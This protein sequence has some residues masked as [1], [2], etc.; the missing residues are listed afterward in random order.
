[1][2]R[3]AVAALILALPAAAISQDTKKTDQK[4]AHPSIYDEKVDAKEQIKTA[5]ALARRDARRVL[6]MF[7]FN[8]C[9]WC[10]KLHGLFASDEAIRTLLADEYVLAMVDVQAQNA[11]DILRDCKT[12]LSR[13][14]LQKGVGYPFLAVLDG[15]G[16]V[17]TAQRTDPLEVGDHHDPGKV[18]AFLEKWVA[19]KVAASKVFEDG[20]AK[21]SRDDKLVFLHFGAPWCGWCH[22]LE[23]FLARD[24][25]APIFGREFVDVK[26]DLDRMA[27][28]R[29]IL[30]RYNADASGGIPWFVFLDARGTAIVTSDGPKGNIG[31]PGTP[32]GIEH[33]IV[34]LKKAARKLDRAQIEMVEAALKAERIPLFITKLKQAVR[35][36]DRAQI[37]SLIEMVEAARKAEAKKIEAS[38]TS[39]KAQ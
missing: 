33:F 5:T 36:H 29:E 10:H 9:G 28:A 13:E 16:R 18:K 14:E 21:A 38:R 17:V 15:N 22:K 39:A 6:V 27:G 8:G 12:A 3:S 30:K 7:G 35:K 4:P 31:Y 26:L 11:D 34:M 2:I 32:E 19:P 1:M 24:D 37:E 20:L 23:A 25:M